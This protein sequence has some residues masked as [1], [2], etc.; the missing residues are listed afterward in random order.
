MQ[1]QLTLLLRKVFTDFSR[2]KKTQ[3]INLF[4]CQIMYSGMAQHF[5]QRQLIKKMYMG[6]FFFRLRFCCPFLRAKMADH[7]CHLFVIPWFSLGWK[8]NV[9]LVRQMYKSSS[10]G[11]LTVYRL[12]LTVSKTYAHALYEQYKS[13]LTLTSNPWQIQL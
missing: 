9:L 3:F 10:W 12:L 5:L 6:F 11:L 1:N 13:E 7:N 8:H 4:L 2:S